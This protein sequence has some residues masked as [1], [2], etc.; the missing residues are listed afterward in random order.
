MPTS[1]KIEINP[2]GLVKRS[3]PDENEKNRSLVSKIVLENE[4]AKGLN[5]IEE[6]SHVYVIFFMHEISDKE[7]C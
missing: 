3:S 7:K 1:Q 6:W 2:I 5:D 4:F